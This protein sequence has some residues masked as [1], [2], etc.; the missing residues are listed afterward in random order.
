MATTI[1]GYSYNAGTS[2]PCY[3]AISIYTSEDATSAAGSRSK[4]QTLYFHSISSYANQSWS[5]HDYKLATNSSATSV[6]CFCD[7]DAFPYWVFTLLM[8]VV[9]L[10]QVVKVNYIKVQ[11]L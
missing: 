5:I 7:E 10:L 11:L 6:S 2:F 8:V 3:K 9:V 1:R 4:G